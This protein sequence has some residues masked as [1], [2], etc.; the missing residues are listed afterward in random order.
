MVFVQIL[1]YVILLY[2][3]YGI[4]DLGAYYYFYVSGEGKMAGG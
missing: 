3:V 2:A 1:R 4:S